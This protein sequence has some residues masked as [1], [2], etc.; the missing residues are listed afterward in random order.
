M[1]PAAV[2]A[3]TLLSGQP[4]RVAVTDAHDRSARVIFLAR[5]CAGKGA[6]RET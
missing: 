1:T 2:S 3:E 4:H 6:E 5:W